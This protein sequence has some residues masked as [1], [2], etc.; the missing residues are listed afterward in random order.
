YVT[1]IRG[2]YMFNDLTPD[3]IDPLLLAQASV[4]PLHTVIGLRKGEV[5]LTVDPSI[6]KPVRI[7]SEGFVAYEHTAQRKVEDLVD[8]LN[9]VFAPFEISFLKADV[10]V[11][12][13]IWPLD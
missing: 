5:T 3:L 11:D 12:D 1:R 10:R 9:R 6:R 2:S 4:P 7:K 8:T 13:S